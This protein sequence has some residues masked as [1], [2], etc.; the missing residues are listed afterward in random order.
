MSKNLL[1]GT[2]RSFDMPNE[3][4]H[5]QLR[6]KA[7][8]LLVSGCLA[9]MMFPALALAQPGDDAF[10]QERLHPYQNR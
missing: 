1:E 4:P 9:L 8:A 3:A 2:R 10:A 5:K 6:R 7:G